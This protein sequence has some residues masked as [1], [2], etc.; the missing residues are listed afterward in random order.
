MNVVCLSYECTMVHVPHLCA[1]C[2]C[3]VLGVCW[4]WHV[5]LY[6]V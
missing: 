2:V 1:V 6:G 5:V 4:V 3:W